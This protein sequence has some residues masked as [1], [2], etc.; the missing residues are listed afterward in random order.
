MSTKNFFW[1]VWLRLNLLTKDVPNDYVAEVSTVGK[2][3]SNADI[4]LIISKSSEVEYETL[5]DILNRADRI[6]RE[7]LQEGCCVQ[8]DICH[9]TPRVLGNWVGAAASFD[10]AKHHITL[11]I[12]PTV[13][14]RAALA[15]VGVEVL[16]IREGGAFIGLVTDVTTGATDGSITAGGQ[17][18]IAGEKIKIEP[19]NEADFG[20]FITDGTTDYPVT[21]L[22]VNHPKE[23]IAIAPQLPAGDYTLYISTKFSS[24]Q[25][26][27]N[28]PRKITYATL[29]T[30]N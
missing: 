23:I 8:T 11:S 15:E 3:L 20:V 13:E 7:K 16:G 10:S 1:K 12:T 9:L 19:T 28:E 24:G 29:I 2:T 6:R 30:V 5:F 21:P 18:I 22:A 26:L 27:L 4:A 14:M 25:T 17:I